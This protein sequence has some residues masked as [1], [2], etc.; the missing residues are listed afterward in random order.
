MKRLWIILYN[1][2]HGTDAFPMFREEPP[3]KEE[4]INALEGAWEGEEYDE[5]IEAVGPFDL[6]AVDENTYTLDVDGPLFR[7]QRKWLID[8]VQL[9]HHMLQGKDTALLSI[10]RAGIEILD[11]LINLTDSIAD[12]AHDRHGLDCLLG[13]NEHIATDEERSYGPHHNKNRT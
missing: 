13:D 9:A 5:D 10:D 8:T 3:S 1:H 11:G 7:R 2:R 4:M 12:E 6:P